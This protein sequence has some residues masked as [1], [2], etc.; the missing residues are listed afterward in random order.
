[1]RLCLIIFAHL[2]LAGDKFFYNYFYLK[3]K[4]YPYFFQFGSRRSFTDALVESVLTDGTSPLDGL[5]AV[6]RQAMVAHL[7]TLPRRRQPA[8]ERDLLLGTPTTSGGIFPPPP[9]HLNVFLWFLLTTL[10]L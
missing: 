1:M 7:D 6:E 3:K 8:P 9:S 4:F 2:W 10:A 5:S